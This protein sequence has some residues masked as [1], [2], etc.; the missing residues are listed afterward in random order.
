MFYMSINIVWMDLKIKIK[1]NEI[2]LQLSKHSALLKDNIIY[3]QAKVQNIIFLLPL[4]NKK[5]R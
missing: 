4:N 1:T 3:Q 2:K 5:P